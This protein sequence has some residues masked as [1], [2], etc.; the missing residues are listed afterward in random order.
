[1]TQLDITALRYFVAVAEELHFT[2]AAARLF[3]AQQAL[4]RGIARLEHQLGT[5]LF[6]RN[7]RRVRLTPAGERL[8]NRARE[9]VVLHDRAIAEVVGISRPVV[10]D[11]HSH[12]RRTGPRV[13]DRARKIAPHLEFRGRNS[14]GFGEALFALA[15]GDIDV[16]FG[17][18]AGSGHL[19]EGLEQ[20]LIRLE[21]LA[22][23][24]PQDH[25]LARESAVALDRIRGAELDAG[26]NNPKAPEWHDLVTQFLAFSG[27]RPT[28]PHLPAEGLDEQADHLARQGLPILTAVDHT[29]VQGGVL[30]VLEKPTP[31]YPWSIVYRTDS[32]ANGTQALLD[33]AVSLG[34]EEG[35]LQP[36]PSAWLPEP[37]ASV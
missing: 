37:E 10:V 21:P 5:P 4:S 9:L 8:L 32:H 7:T 13:L 12:G 11:L 17:R 1:M 20:R 2:R 18:T 36:P 29:P 23:L 22:L 3:V 16:A 19:P 25:P 28:P 15:A 34:C 30:R 35:W 14:S 24:L 27:A 6:V 26:V 33:A 31:L